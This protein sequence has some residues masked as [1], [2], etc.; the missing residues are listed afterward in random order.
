MLTSPRRAD[1]DADPAATTR[2]GAVAGEDYDPL[3]WAAL[4][5]LSGDGPSALPAD[6]A[7]FGEWGAL[8]R[9]LA[10]AH[11]KAVRVEAALEPFARLN[12]AQAAMLRELGMELV[13]NAVLH[14]IESMSMR[15]RIGKD[16]VGAVRLDLSFDERAGWLLCVCDDGRGVNLVRV[17]AALVRDGGLSAA[18][19]AQL[20]ERETI[21]KVFEPGVTTALQA[22]GASGRGLGL[23][24]VL[25]RLSGLNARVS[26]ATAPGRSTE[27]RIAW[28][29]A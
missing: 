29:A 1:A 11:G 7:M 28:P 12:A 27:V 26:L 4:L 15:R 17:R 19:A 21:L 5:A 24:A 22:D 8:A 20:S 25:E 10:G 14:G 18:Q 13:A 3:A 9:R 16:P 6:K 2:L 23:P